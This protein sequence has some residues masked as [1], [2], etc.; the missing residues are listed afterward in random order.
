MYELEFLHL[1][2]LIS[3]AEYVHIL[4]LLK[5]LFSQMIIIIRN[6]IDKIL[7]PNEWK[8]LLRTSAHGTI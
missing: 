4:A 3:S 2:Y 7:C 6:K 5:I 8:K 1:L